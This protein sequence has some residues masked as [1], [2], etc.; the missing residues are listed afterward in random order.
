MEKVYIHETVTYTVGKGFTLSNIVSTTAVLLEGLNAIED[1]GELKSLENML[2]KF[3]EEQ[4]RGK[5]N[6][7]EAVDKSYKSALGSLN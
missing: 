5:T 7:S 1:K 4:E 2:K 3:K 6:M